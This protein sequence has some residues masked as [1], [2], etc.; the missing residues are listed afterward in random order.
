MKTKC[1]CGEPIKEVWAVIDAPMP[2]GDLGGCVYAITTVWGSCG[3]G[4]HS[5]NL[6]QLPLLS[7]LEQPLVSIEQVKEALGLN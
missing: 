1:S 6:G 3:N 2:P 7:I 4:C 5:V